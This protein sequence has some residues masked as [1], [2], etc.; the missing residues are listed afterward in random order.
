MSSISGN[1][2]LFAGD[3]T[4]TSCVLAG[5]LVNHGNYLINNG[6]DYSS[7]KDG[8]AL[9]K[10]IMLSILKKIRVSANDKKHL[11]NLSMIT[12]LGDTILS[13]VVSNAVY[14]AKNLSDIILEES[15]YKETLLINTNAFVIPNGI[16]D[17]EIYNDIN[18]K[19]QNKNKNLHN[20]KYEEYKKLFK[21]KEEFNN[22]TLKWPLILVI[23][24]EIEHQIEIEGSFEFAKELN[25]PLIIFCKDIGDDIMSYIKKFNKDNMN[26]LYKV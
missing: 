15:P 1:T 11:Y 9:S 6:Y 3:G 17:Y 16:E 12:T 2:N 20:N 13:D 4:T 22:N 7:I 10:D 24:K 21:V 23:D 8:I 19:H 14:N 25:K 26:N 18:Y 5:F